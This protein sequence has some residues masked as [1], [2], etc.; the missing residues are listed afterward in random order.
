MEGV[1]ISTLA[2]CL[3]RV[4]HRYRCRRVVC[5]SSNQPDPSRG[6]SLVMV[7]VAPFAGVELLEATYRLIEK[8]LLLDHIARF[9]G[10]LSS[11]NRHIISKY[12]SKYNNAK[13]CAPCEDLYPKR[14][15]DVMAVLYTRKATTTSSDTQRSGL[16]VHDERVRPRWYHWGVRGR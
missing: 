7:F 3:L 8:S 15:P 13:F 16:L 10:L 14:T 1:E 6:N 4:V 5:V 11:L 2:H 12:L 9:P